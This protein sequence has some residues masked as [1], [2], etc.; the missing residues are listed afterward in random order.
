MSWWRAVPPAAAMM[1]VAPWMAEVSWGGLL[2]TDM[3]TIVLFLGP[4]YGGAALLIREWAR[5][6]GR[7]WAS[8][9]LLGAAFGLLQCGLVDQSLFNPSYDRFDFQYPVHVPGLSFSVV[10]LV[11]FVTGHALMSIAVPI[12]LV[13]SGVARRGPWLGRAGTTVL[14]LLYGC[15]TLL[16]FVGVREAER[17]QAELPQMLA[18]VVVVA[19]LV[20]A[21]H[22]A[23]PRPRSDGPVPPVWSLAVVGALGYLYYQPTTT[24]IG[25]VVAT[26]VLGAAW[27]TLGRLSAR[28]C[29]TPG[30]TTA[31][32]VGAAF[33]HVVGVFANEPYQLVAPEV[34]LVYDLLTASGTLVIV[35]LAVAGSCR[36]NRSQ[37]LLDVWPRRPRRGSG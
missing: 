35:L 18:V 36:R 1:V 25:L 27:F 2:P 7:G 19:A 10:H 16:N 24:A 3:L 31:L 5:R 37:T 30:H 11:S 14:A 8:I 9:L 33:T 23:R 34:E 20:A 17:F 12:A 15:A 4:L 6:T 21:A 29:W 32:A 13:E 22:R 26:A 28:A